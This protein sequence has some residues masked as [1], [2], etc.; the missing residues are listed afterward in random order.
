MQTIAL[1]ELAQGGGNAPVH[2]FDELDFLG[3]AR[4]DRAFRLREELE[5]GRPLDAL[6][7]NRGTDELVFSFHGALNREK[8]VLP[9]FER[10]NMILGHEVSGVFFG[11]PTLHVSPDI[12]LAWF[13]G[14]DGVDVHRHIAR[15]SLE[16]AS[17]VGASRLIFT[18]SSGGGFAALQVSALVPGSVAVAFNAQTDIANYRV[19]GTSWGVQ[20]EYVRSVWPAVW[21]RLDPAT[22]VE[23]GA[24]AESV[25]DRVS[26]VERYSKSRRNRVYLVQN[27]EEFHYQDHFQPFLESALRGGNDVIPSINREGK[28]HNPPRAE[29]FNAVLADVLMRERAGARAL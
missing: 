23:N 4:D 3:S 18:G 15:R 16:I 22:V 11:D 26:A 2:P 9:R 1:A 5:P 29:T 24:W 14:W 13:T 10:L 6:V 27:E 28:L 7:V 25:D 17:A 8:T 21:D 12:Q 19:N 20:R